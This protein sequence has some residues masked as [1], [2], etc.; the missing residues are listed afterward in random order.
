[1]DGVF[2]AVRRDV[3]EHL[4]FDE[5]RFDGFHLYDVDFT[6]SANLA[7]FRLGVANDLYPLHRSGGRYDKVWRGY[8]KRFLDKRGGQLAR[9]KDGV[10]R[11]SYLEVETK[12]DVVRVMTPG[13]WRIPDPAVWSEALVEGAAVPAEGVGA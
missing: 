6:F 9:V 3:L 12:A 10:R 8:A 4:P 1:M 13:H 2:L 5:K 11:W 7:G